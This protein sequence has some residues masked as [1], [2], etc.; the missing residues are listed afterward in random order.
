[1]NDSVTFSR[2]YDDVVLQFRPNPAQ[3]P[4]AAKGKDGDKSPIDGALTP[5][6]HGMW[7]YERK[8]PALYDSTDKDDLLMRSVISNYALEGVTDGAPN[9]KF[10]LTQPIFYQV[11]AEV[12]GTHIGYSGAKLKAYL[13]EHVPTIFKHLDVNNQGWI[14]AEKAP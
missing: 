14:I 11:G 3:S 1:M 4:W 13:D 12:V 9:G 10:Y 8:V 2:P 5:F 6:H 7:D